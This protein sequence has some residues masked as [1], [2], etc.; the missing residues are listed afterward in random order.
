MR[1]RSV[2]YGLIGLLLMASL[3]LLALWQGWGRAITPADVPHWNTS[4]SSVIRPLGRTSFEEHVLYSDVI[5]RVSLKSVAQTVEPT[6]YYGG[7]FVPP[8]YA[9]GLEF[10]LE[11]HE[12]LKGTG[13]VEVVAVAFDRDGWFETEEEVEALGNYLLDTR[14]S[15]WDDREAIV[16]LRSSDPL[17][18][19][20]ANADR[21]WLGYAWRFGR[22]D[23]QV[24]ATWHRAWL[25]ERGATTISVDSDAVRAQALASD[26][27][28]TFL[29]DVLGDVAVG[30]EAMAQG[31]DFA[32]SSDHVITLSS[33]KSRIAALEAEAVGGD[34]SQAWRDCIKAKYRDARRLQWQKD[35]GLKPLIYPAATPSGQ[36]AATR[37]YRWGAAAQGR[38]FEFGTDPPQDILGQMDHES[39]LLGGDASLFTIRY[40]YDVH[41]TR[42]LPAGEYAFFTDSR[43][44]VLIPCDGWPLERQQEFGVELTVTA[45]SGTVHEAFFDPVALTGTGV[46]AD[47]T[48]NGDL[49][50]AAFTIGDVDSALQ[51]L[52]WQGGSVVLTLSPYTSLTGNAIDFIELDASVSLT[53]SADAATVDSAAGT[54]TWSVATQPWH[55]GDLIM[56]RIRDATVPAQTPVPTA[57]PTPSASTG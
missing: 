1:R 12:Y 36:P 20:T 31:A 45:P 26:E 16:F 23:Y 21:Y 52:T 48:A 44:R 35:I 42:P 37:V 3:A 56:L 4:H 57:E 29:L 22:P 40:P 17:L 47:T 46:G 10:T 50:P 28:Q 7:T 2:V 54:L 55:D 13:P 5:A 19:S 39:R 43:P 49:S 51:S 14:D 41:A 25:P 38:L 18:P 34:G 15:G 32:N 30:Q 33:L 6:P 9:G 53:L 11:V 24:T 8:W 27:E